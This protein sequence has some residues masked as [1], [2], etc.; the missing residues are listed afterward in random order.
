MI[1]IGKEKERILSNFEGFS[2]DADVAEAAELLYDL[3]NHSYQCSRD[4]LEIEINNHRENIQS[5]FCS[6]QENID[7]LQKIGAKANFL[8]MSVLEDTFKKCL[9]LLLVRVEELADGDMSQIENVNKIRKIFTENEY[10]NAWKEKAAAYK[11]IL[12]SYGMSLTYSD[13]ED[14]SAI[15]DPFINAMTDLDSYAA[16]KV[17][18]VRRGKRAEV[19]PVFINEISI[20][21]SEQEFADAIMT[22]GKEAVVAFGGIEYQNWQI[23]DR[24]HNSVYGYPEERKRNG[25]RNNDFTEEEYDKEIDAYSQKILLAVKDNEN[26]YFIKMPYQRDQCPVTEF[27]DKFYYGE[28]AGYAPYEVFFKD[29]NILPKDSTYLIVPKKSWKL[30][31][32]MDDMAKIWLPMFFFFYCYLGYY[33]ELDLGFS[34][35]F[36]ID[37]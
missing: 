29:L 35:Y 34:I 21:N 4:C 22:C 19:M 14:L 5:L 16:R 1:L 6:C 15:V 3:L 2:F 32:I 13:Y 31:D 24:M 33:T 25:M 12:E 37:L 17:M 30:N 23:E 18:R 26:L 8:A 9:P 28:R 11:S 20:Y 27:A 36:G 7:K 10:A